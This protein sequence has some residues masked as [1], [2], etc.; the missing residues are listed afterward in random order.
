ML[1]V[2]VVR[3]PGVP[4]APPADATAKLHDARRWPRRSL[5]PPSWRAGLLVFAGSAWA[6]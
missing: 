3:G 6:Q 2:I 1:F 5:R 4:L